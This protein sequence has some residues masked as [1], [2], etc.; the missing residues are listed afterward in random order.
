MS[1]LLSHLEAMAAPPLAPSDAILVLI[2]LAGGND[3]LNTVVP[4]NDSNYYA[5]RPSIGL[6]PST[7]LNVNGAVG[8]HPALTS[9]KQHFDA[10]HVAVIQGVG[11]N[12]PDFSHF[13]SMGAWMQGWGGTSVSYPTGWI[14]RYLD[15]LPNA[16]TESLYA[17]SLNTNGVPLHLVGQTG[18][19][20]SLPMSVG[21]R[22][23][24]DRS[25]QDNARL[26]DDL[27][28]FS[29]S[30]DTDLG[31][32]GD[33]IA[34]AGAQLLRL[35]GR[36]AP[37]YPPSDSVP[38]DSCARQMQLV[39]RLVNRNLGIRVF[40]VTLDGFDTHTGQL[41][42]H[43][44][45]MAS[46]D[47]G[48]N[49][50]MS[51]LDPAWQ[52]NV[53]GLTFSELGRR[54]SENDGGGTDHGSAG[55]SLAIGMRVKGG[56]YGAAPSLAPNALVDYGNLEATVDYRSMYATILSKW[57]AADDRQIL[58]SHYPQLGFV[59]SHP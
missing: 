34:R 52:D 49:T 3:A 11:V 15:G 50:L 18:R 21:G 55:T 37:A 23:G 20:S 26:Y 29:A 12:P 30:G 4:I 44:T 56:M 13:S 45:L 33:A 36:I 10:G 51:T 5:M 47:L 14:G 2:M 6:A 16:S 43:A 28:S 46:L 7:T 35:T 25:D 31:T 8:F 42:S 24:V 39:A 27:A 41:A 54:P 40:N 58:G 22:F 19:G 38:E 1:P 48:I 32:N 59:R 57:L 17:V 53:M 9:V